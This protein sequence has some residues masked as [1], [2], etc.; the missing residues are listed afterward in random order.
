MIIN[1]NFLLGAAAPAA[2]AGP[3]PD[4]RRVTALLDYVSGD[5]AR[6]V[7]P[8]G[9][10]LSATELQE[11]EG[12]VEDA[13][14]ELR[15]GASGQGGDLAARCEALA[16]DVAAKA[17]PSFVAS[18]A[19]A[20]RNE[21]ARRYHVALLPQKAPD[22]ARGAQ[23][24]AQACAACHGADGRPRS[25]LEL[26]TKP[27]DFTLREDAGPLSPQRIFTA[28]TYGVPRTQMPA[29]DSGL[30]DQERWDA[31][32]YLLAL[33]H[34]AAAG[35]R[36]KGLE[37]A[38]TALVPTS[39]LELAPLSD[40]EL[41][42]RL[43]KAGLSPPRQD[44]A[45][46]GLR[47]GPF[48]EATV[49]PQALTQA[50]HGVQEAVKLARMGDA[51]G[52]RRVLVSAYL[53]HFE[54][55]EAGLRARDPDL[56]RDIESAFL[57]LRASLDEPSQ[58]EGNAARLDSLLEK[59]DARPAGGGLIAF[60]A[61]LAIALREG[62]EAALLVAALL[63]LLR[64]AGRE[65]D[66]RAVHAGWL[67]ALAAGAVT[68]WLSGALLALVTG[69]QRE[70]IE[71]LLQLVLAAMILYASHWLFA[72]MSSR[73]LMSVFFQ[74]TMAG[75][76]ALVVLGITFT[77]VYREMFEVVLF[78]RGL[79]LEEP[80]RGAA[81]AGG[82]AAGVGVLVALV[83]LFGRI[84]K[85]LRPRLLLM[86]CGALLTGLAV[87]M[88]GNGV[89]SLQI[90]GALPLTVWGGFELPSLGLYATREGIVSQSLVLLGLGGSALWNYVHQHVSRPA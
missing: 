49:Q 87:L 83:A 11:Q 39:Y 72:A 69:A 21:I 23:V 38:R 34:P 64:K 71:G 62:V 13:A 76:S 22:L 5:Y 8:G 35:A 85:K 78:F 16:R 15:A 45:L 24:Y 7:G 25:D 42:A 86:G 80:G 61:A 73:K 26:Q 50:R 30:S 89:R 47:G 29:F 60:A 63:A 65:S 10:L 19:E 84:G 90:V 68:W 53:D 44:E 58:L 48:V 57:A 37:L 46:A 18:E 14:H 88:V 74:R 36:E 41:R 56:V 54:P 2:P 43:G 20:L 59:A 32:F 51:E 79:M 81:V 55:H 75:A 33:A 4:L 82:A 77:S 9:E 3:A 6:A 31:A 67:S 70:W 27:P 40:D 66:A 17:P 1:L 28:S 52:A 12:F